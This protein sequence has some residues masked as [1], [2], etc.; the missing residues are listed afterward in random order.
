VCPR[1]QNPP[2]V[3]LR[4]VQQQTSGT[5]WVQPPEEQE[6]LTRYV[7]TL[8]ERLWLVVAAVAI[9]TGVAIA[10]V[11]FASKTYEAEADLLITPISSS[12]TTIQGLPV[13][14]QSS[15]PTRDVETASRLVTNIDVATR[16]HDQ[17]GTGQSARSL[18]ED[19]TAQP[20][21]NSTIVAVKGSAGSPEAARAL[22][23][24]FAEQAVAEQTDAVHKA[25]QSVLPGIEAR[26]RRE[27]LPPTDPLR[28]TAAQY[29]QLLSGPTP[30]MHLSTP[31]ELPTSPA[32]PRVKLSLA[33]GLIGGLVLGV[34]A[35]FASQA[36]D[37]RLRREEQLRRLYRL[38][39]LARIPKESGRS[40][41]PLS[42]LNLSPAT[43]EAYRTLRG[44]LTTSRRGA[45]TEP[46]AI[47]VTGSSPSEGKTTTAVNLAASLAAAGHSV[48][49]IE[50]DLRRPAIAAALGTRP[51]SGV[52]SVLIES[53]DLR[54]ALVTS[55]VLGANLGLLLADYEGGWIS[56]LFALPAAGELIAEARKLADYVVIDSPPL[57]DVIDALPLASYVDDVL[58]VV[59]IG[60]T[61]LRK[62]TNLGELLTENGIRPAGFAVIGT[63]RPSRSDYHYYAG[64]GRTQSAEEAPPIRTGSRARPG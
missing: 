44:L 25:I 18:L 28:A 34:L 27:N 58:L 55:P 15:D 31:A 12:D 51:H 30:D 1:W 24:A 38:P 41:Q 21:A 29:Q 35:A 2:A 45:G 16:V 42:P 37:P 36:L 49:L 59:R 14:V 52:V 4:G 6:G 53:V 9:T 50:A 10:Y 23:N 64:R 13:I 33:A 56:E 3:E 57:T 46:R 11:V 43:G 62:L 40:G 47:L 17:L 26:V 61:N 5:G 8:R 63:P 7:E 19:V 60:K 20:V 48:V 39:I 22:A 54:D 32:S